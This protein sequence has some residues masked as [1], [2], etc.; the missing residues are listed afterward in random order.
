MPGMNGLVHHFTIDQ[1][2][3]SSVSK[4]TFMVLM[5]GLNDDRLVW[6]FQG[7]I[8]IQLVNQKKQ[9]KSV[10]IEFDKKAASRGRADRAVIEDTSDLGWRFSQ[11]VSHRRVE[12]VTDRSQYITDDCLTFSIADITIKCSITI[13]H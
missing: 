4:W 7:S 2:A 8:E 6:P 3:T 5:K 11:F 9:N 10:V 13:T 12:K 1:E